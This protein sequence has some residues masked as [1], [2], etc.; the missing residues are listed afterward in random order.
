MFSQSLD[1]SNDVGIPWKII[2]YVFGCEKPR[3]EEPKVPC[4]NGGICGRFLTYGEIGIW[5]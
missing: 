4:L 3:I 5:Y 2:G 1:G